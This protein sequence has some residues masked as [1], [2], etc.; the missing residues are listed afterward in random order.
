MVRLFD[1]T[2]ITG[3]ALVVAALIVAGLAVSRVDLPVLG[4]G[5]GALIG[6]AVLGIAGCAV[7]GISQAPAVGWT[8]PTI[9]FG[10]LLGVLALIVIL[11]G[12]LGWTGILAPVAQVLPGQLASATTVQTATLLLAAIIAVKWLVGA[13]MAVA[14]R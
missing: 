2:F 13:G 5:I 6:V 12:L 10:S 1:S 3:T 14:A 9:V 11:A 7:A 8:A 4:S